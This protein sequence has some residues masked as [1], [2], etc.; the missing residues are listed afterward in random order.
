M[1]TSA[2]MIVAIAEPAVPRI[3]RERPAT[4]LVFVVEI[5]S[6]MQCSGRTQ[7]H[8]SVGRWEVMGKTLVLRSET[9]RLV[10]ASRSSTM[11]DDVLLH[12]TQ[13]LLGAVNGL[14]QIGLSRKLYEKAQLLVTLHDGISPPGEPALQHLVEALLQQAALA[15]LGLLATG[16]SGSTAARGQDAQV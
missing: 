5:W 7:E 9:C 12:T 6:K 11:L 8:F 1:A 10:L 16:P 13:R 2:K 4:D 3:V 15:G 14:T